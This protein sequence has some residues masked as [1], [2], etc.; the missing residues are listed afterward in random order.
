MTEIRARF[1]LAAL[2]FSAT[3]SV[4]PVFAEVKDTDADGLTDEGEMT[5]YRTDPGRADTDGDAVA[6]GDEV[7]AG[8]DPLDA[9]VIPTIGLPISD[10]GILGESSKSA[11]YLTR[12]S[13]ILAFILLSLS[14]AFGLVMSSRALTRVVPGAEA[15]EWHRSLSLASVAAVFLHAGSLFF[16]SFL[17]LSFAEIFVPFLFDRAGLASASG[18]PLR[19]PIGFGVTAFYLALI[20]VL[21]A[22]FR[23]KLPP[24]LWRVVHYASFVAYPLFV[25]HGFMSGSDSGE[26]WMRAIYA[27]SVVLVGSLVSIRVWSR[28]IR[29]LFRRSR[30]DTPAS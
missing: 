9:A 19:V 8:S 7:L 10:P 27:V 16:E 3:C 5:I 26:W 4:S 12:A 1:V 24:R 29:P 30:P 20:L 2:L 15:Y 6:D 13:G 17:N 21:T 23:T 14:S 28:N 11:W 25:A 18:F 22:E